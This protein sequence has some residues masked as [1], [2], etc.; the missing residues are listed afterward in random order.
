[1]LYVLQTCLTPLLLL[2]TVSNGFAELT[3]K[4]QL[5]AYKKAKKYYAAANYQRAQEMLAP[6]IAVEEKIALTPYALFYYALAAYYQGTTGLAAHIF[7]KIN[8]EFPDWQQRNSVLYWLAQLAFEQDDYE[9]GLNYLTC[10]PDPS[11]KKPV[12]QI[13]VHFLQRIEDTNVLQNL[14]E[15]YPEDLILAQLL[16]DKLHNKPFIKQDH[17]DIHTLTERFNG[18]LELP[19]CPLTSWKK[20]SYNVAVLLP[21]LLDE[22]AYEEDSSNQFVLALYSGI[23]A[24]VD[25]L[26]NQGTRI[27]LFAYDT[28]KSPMIT[29]TLLAKEEI[30][31]MDLIIGPLDD[32]VIPLVADFAQQ[33][34][35]NLFNPLAVHADV[36]GSNPFSYLFKPSLETQAR[37]AAAFTQSM[38]QAGEVIRVGIVY[39]MSPADTIKAHTYKQCI[40]RHADQEIAF[41]LELAP[42]VAQQFLSPFR[43]PKDGLAV[44]PSFDGLTHIY[45]ASQDELII[46]DVLSAIEIMHINP[47]IIGDEA[48]LRHNFITLDQL[49][50]LDLRLIAP[51]Y[52]DYEKA[53]LHVFRNDFYEQFGGY[54]TYDAIVGYNMMLFLGNMLAKYGVYFQKHWGNEWVPGAL[55]PGFFYGQHHDNQHVP[56]V[57]FH[58]STLVI[59]Q[60]STP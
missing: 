26:A 10:L 44:K 27:N 20:D 54:P 29:A 11:W 4:A 47:C 57:K 59:C 50:R 28:K 53:S 17:D 25:T 15:K 43:T 52:V 30:K 31:S 58:K 34:Q 33:H 49:Q 41:M 1:M 9:T 18:V 14:L 42:A 21:F 45:I 55:S 16:L 38:Q 3:E 35:I 60:A 2:T 7:L 24:A 40:E 36:V 37:T 6:L 32:A 22:I 56:I 48:W 5:K 8:Q 51:D 12:K 46:A 19:L 23:Q 39:G 13:K